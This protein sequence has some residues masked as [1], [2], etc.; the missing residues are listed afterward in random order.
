MLV[1]VYRPPGFSVRDRKV[2]DDIIA[3]LD[4]VGSGL[5]RSTLVISGDFNQPDV[6]WVNGVAPDDDVQL[7]LLNYFVI[8]GATQHVNQPT[9]NRII[10]DLFSHDPI[11]GARSCC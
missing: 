7:K 10:L 9:R 1:N 6:E 5:N 11:I 3:Y 4:Y 2:C 8:I